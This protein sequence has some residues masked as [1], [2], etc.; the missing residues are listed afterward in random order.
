MSN[1]SRLNYDRILIGGSCGGLDLV[2]KLFAGEQWQALPPIVYACHI[3]K[4]KSVNHLCEL[5]KEKLPLEVSIAAPGEKLV[6]NHFYLSPASYHILLEDNG[7]TFRYYDDGPFLS[8]KPSINLFFMSCCGR[9][10]KTTLVILASGANNDGAKGMH[11]LGLHGATCAI[12]NPVYCQFDEM[13]KAAMLECKDY[14]LIPHGS[15]RKWL[16]GKLW[17]KQ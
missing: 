7:E 12:V 2:L 5:L 16:Q 11:E 1:S 14:E 15:E 17:I 6:N 13:P 8:S 4:E 9:E 3:S 10:A